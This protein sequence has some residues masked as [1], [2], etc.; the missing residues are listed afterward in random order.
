MTDHSSSEPNRSITIPER[1]AEEIEQ[2]LPATEFDSVDEYVAFTMELVLRELDKNHQP[3][4]A[5]NGDSADHE[6]VRD[7]LEKLGYL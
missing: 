3:N 2:R 4:P 6:E 7:Q 5:T 1:T